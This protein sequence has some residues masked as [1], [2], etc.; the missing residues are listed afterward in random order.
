MPEILYFTGFTW[1]FYI[2]FLSSY[3]IIEVTTPIVFTQERRKFM[4]TKYHQISLP[5]IF[6]DCQNMFMEET[7]SFFSAPCIPWNEG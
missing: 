5:E 6:S 2:N 4:A 3:G 1:F 7:P